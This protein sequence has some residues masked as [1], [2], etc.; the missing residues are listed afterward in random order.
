[1]VNTLRINRLLFFSVLLSAVVHGQNNL[2]IID[3]TGKGISDVEASALTDRLQNELLPLAKYKL[4]ER[5]LIENI[6]FEQGL[7]QTGC[8]T[9]ECI[10]EIGKLLGVDKIIGGSISKIG[11][12]YSIYA[13]IIS[14]GT[15]EIIK[16]ST[17]DYEG[18][19]EH[20]LVYGMKYIAYD[21]CELN[22]PNFIMKASARI[23]KLYIEG[24][25]LY[26]GEGQDNFQLDSYDK[27]IDIF[28]EIL[29]MPLN[30]LTDNAQYWKAECYYS[31]KK[32]AKA[33]EEFEK[34]LSYSNSE[35]DDD[36]QLKLGIANDSLGNIDKAREEYLRIIIY[37]PSSEYYY[38][39]KMALKDIDNKKKQTN[40]NP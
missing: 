37:Y 26:S 1:M 15:G 39:A 4:V 28:N 12:M 14:I 22:P 38:K 6:L 3:F 31:Q 36:A 9:N 20:L 24:L 5:E 34:V 16:S 29:K 19:I 10:I 13:K 27:A 7:Q 2:A 33:I 17:F 23:K 21:I 35:K 32:Y 18:D 40:E 8:I 11:N 25:N 30:E